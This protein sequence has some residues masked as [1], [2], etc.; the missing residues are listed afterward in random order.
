MQKSRSQLCLNQKG[1]Q[2]LL[3]ANRFLKLSS[4]L[5]L[6][7][8]LAVSLSINTIEHKQVLDQSCHLAHLS[9]CLPVWQP[10]SLSDG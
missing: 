10:V 9:V 6:K 2:T 8:L 7:S 1:A 5:S 3:N 4:N